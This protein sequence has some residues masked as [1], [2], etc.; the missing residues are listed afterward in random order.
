M[1]YYT[2]VNATRRLRATNRI[3]ELMTLP[4][5]QERSTQDRP[6]AVTRLAA[7]GRQYRRS[8]RR[9]RPGYPYPDSSDRSHRDGITTPKL[10]CLRGPS[11]VPARPVEPRRNAVKEFLGMLDSMGESRF[12]RTGEILP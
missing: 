8:Q 9:S 4:E 6:N 2:R 7:S 10:A 11:V 3:A 1:R 5:G 12:K